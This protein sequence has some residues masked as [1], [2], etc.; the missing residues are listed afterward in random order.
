MK[1]SLQDHIFWLLLL[2]GI[3]DISTWMV[4][5]SKAAN[6]GVAV[7]I[8]F[9][10]KWNGRKFG[11]HWMDWLIA[12]NKKIVRDPGNILNP[13]F[14]LNHCSTVSPPRSFNTA[15]G[16][17]VKM[18][19]HYTHINVTFFQEKSIPIWTAEFSF[20]DGEG[21]LSNSK[22]WR[23]CANPAAKRARKAEELSETHG[24]MF[25]AERVLAYVI[26]AIR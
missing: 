15:T 11:W 8:M 5:F 6:L 18:I 19:H 20:P 22:H 26:G 17:F 25:L 13:G 7:S 10:I 21:V 24:D 12:F 4:S 1:D 16:L 14:L 3:D 23:W 9:F 2:L